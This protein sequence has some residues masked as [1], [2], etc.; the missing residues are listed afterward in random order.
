MQRPPLEISDGDR[1]SQSLNGKKLGA[2]LILVLI[3]LRL[4]I[5]FLERPDKVKIVCI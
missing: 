4:P 5:L 2:V 3:F 1:L